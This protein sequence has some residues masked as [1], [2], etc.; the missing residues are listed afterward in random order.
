MRLSQRIRNCCCLRAVLTFLMAKLPR[1]SSELRAI[2]IY[3]T[4]L[5]FVFLY[6]KITTANLYIK[7]D[8]RTH[9]RSNLDTHYKWDYI[10]V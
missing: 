2:D 9:P 1:T 6:L 10:L 8:S 4:L 3:I 7:S 5:A